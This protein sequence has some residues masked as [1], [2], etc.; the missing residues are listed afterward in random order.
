MIIKAGG[1]G[2]GSKGEA[3]APR[4]NVPSSAKVSSSDKGITL[5]SAEVVVVMK[6]D[7]DD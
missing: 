1:T 7:V 4:K 2:K 3:A 5:S 6:N